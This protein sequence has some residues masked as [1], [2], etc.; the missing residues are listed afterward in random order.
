M[1]LE[2]AVEKASAFLENKAGYYT[3]Y[4]ESVKLLEKVWVVKFN[5]GAF[6]EKIVEVKIDNEIEK[7]INEE[8][9]ETE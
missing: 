3:H 4:L 8:V 1:N 6:T 5:V 7:V 9:C 2:E